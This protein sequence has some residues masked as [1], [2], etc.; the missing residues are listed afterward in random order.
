VLG[1]ARSAGLGL[2]NQRRYGLRG[3]AEGHPALRGWRMQLA[4][5]EYRFP[6]GRVERGLT[7]PPVGL[8]QWSGTAFVE[9]GAAWDEERPGR[10]HPAAGVEAVL[11][12]VAGF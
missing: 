2:F 5:A 1:G 8:V 6:L 9:A 3:Y 11:D 4:T 10:L 7:A 12:A